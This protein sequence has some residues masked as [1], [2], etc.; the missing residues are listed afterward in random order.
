MSAK[1]EKRR[2]QYE[3]EAYREA[4][5]LWKCREPARAFFVRRIFWRM[6][7]PSMPKGV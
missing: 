5:Y 4:L 2:R 7:K 1:Q 3:R 6:R